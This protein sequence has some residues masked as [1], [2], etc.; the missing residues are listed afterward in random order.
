MLFYICIKP[1]VI[2]EVAVSDKLPQAVSLE[3]MSV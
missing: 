3:S 2:P 1:F